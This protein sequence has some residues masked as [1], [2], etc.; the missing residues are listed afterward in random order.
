VSLLIY[1]YDA[2]SPTLFYLLAT[3]TAGHQ[4]LPSAADQ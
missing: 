3:L 4:Y 1:D 2:K